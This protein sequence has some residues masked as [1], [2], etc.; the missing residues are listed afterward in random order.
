MSPDLKLARTSPSREQG[1]Y[2]AKRDKGTNAQEEKLLP[3]RCN[4]CTGMT[5]ILSL[6]ML[7]GTVCMNK[8]RT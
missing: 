3:G 4:E 7:K 8:S 5:T 6:Y 1:A 2:Q